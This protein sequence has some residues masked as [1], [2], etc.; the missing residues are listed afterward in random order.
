M[1]RIAMVLG[2]TGLA[3]KAVT[4]ELLNHEDWD[5]VRVLLRTPLALEHPKLKQNIIEWDHLAKYSELFKDVHSVFCCLGTTIKKAGSQEKFERV[6]LQYPLEAATL[7]KE[8][9]AKQF[10]L[11]SSMGASAKSRIY[12]NRIKGKVEDGLI[13]IGFQG[14]H[15]FRPS[16][17][18]GHREEF[19]LGE[20]V[21]AGLMK[22]MDRLMVG[23]AAKY[24]AIQGATVAKAMVNIASAETQGLHIYMNDVIHVIGKR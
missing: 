5:E 14:M 20:R 13:A 7:A 17:L 4:E 11:I 22:A 10:L 16:L 3:G 1:L 19:R 2:A 18:L 12:Y 23:D 21:A 15:I 6:D 24:R 8:N 9:G